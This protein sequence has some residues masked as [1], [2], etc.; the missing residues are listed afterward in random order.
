[1]K[2]SNK[3]YDVLKYIVIV[4]LP[5]L[6]VL[7][8]SLAD[9]WNFPYALPIGATIGA[10]TF[11]LGAIIGVSSAKYKALNEVSKNE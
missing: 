1:M 8:L 5:A 2:L 6:E 9:I 4:F 3:V 10:F 7:W 11:F